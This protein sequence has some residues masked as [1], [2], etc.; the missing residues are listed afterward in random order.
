M[1]FL[2][3]EAFH[4]ELKVVIAPLLRSAPYPQNLDG[5]ATPLHKQPAPSDAGTKHLA[6]AP[7]CLSADIRH[8]RSAR[9]GCSLALSRRQMH[10]RQ[11]RS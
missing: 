6:R 11:R 5:R 2:A 8:C 10:R 9:P 3:F 1:I 7:A 4:F